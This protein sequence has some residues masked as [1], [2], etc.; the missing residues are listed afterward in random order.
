MKVSKS[1]IAVTLAALSL[2]VNAATLVVPGTSDPWLAGMPDGTTASLLDGA[3]AQSPVLFS[4]FALTA[5][6]WL[7]FAVTVDPAGGLVGNCAGC[8]V[9]TPDGFSFNA[10]GAGAENG[11]SD[12]NA[13]TNSLVGIFLSDAQPNLTAAPSALDFASLGTSFTTLSPGLKQVFFVGDG[14][15]GSTLQKFLVP[16]DATRLYL[17]TMDGYEWKNNVGAYD[18][19][20]AAVTAVPEPETYAM[21]LSGLGLLG[22]TLRRRGRKSAT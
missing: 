7:N 19:S 17:G 21:M 12:V 5:G 2:G 20:V 22:V 3:P 13:P 9:P 6:S 11:I 15:A 4:D 14:L 8:T 10:H 16:T 1:A 18:V